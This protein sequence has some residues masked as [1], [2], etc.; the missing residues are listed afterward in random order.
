MPPIET[1]TLIAAPT[2]FLGKDATAPGYIATES[3]VALIN[4]SLVG[5]LSG[6]IDTVANKTYY[7]DKAPAPYDINSFYQD[8]KTSGS[9]TVAIKING[10]NVTGLSAVACSTTES[11]TT[12]T[13][14]NHV[15]TG[16]EVSMVISGNSSCLDLFWRLKITGA[17]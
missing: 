10:T 2:H 16:D 1:N 15:A 7:L 5:G 11:E 17:A 6:Q 12:A 4:S 13:A 14:A 3:A 8:V 9:C